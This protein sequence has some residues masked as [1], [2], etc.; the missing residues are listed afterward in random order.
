MSDAPVMTLR[1]KVAG[2]R[3]RLKSVRETLTAA[4]PPALNDLRP[5]G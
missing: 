1:E 5:A 2:E 4:L 3:R